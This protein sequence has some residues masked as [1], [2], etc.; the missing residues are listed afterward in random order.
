MIRA[1]KRSWHVIS[2]IQELV[3]NAVT[4]TGITLSCGTR[5]GHNIDKLIFV[6]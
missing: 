5:T 6:G 1:Q 2:P 3:I 4:V